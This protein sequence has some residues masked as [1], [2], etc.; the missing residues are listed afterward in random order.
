[1][2]SC[3]G[4]FFYPLH[5]QELADQGPGSVEQTHV[6]YEGQA[7]EEGLVGV[8]DHQEQSDNLLATGVVGGNELVS[9]RKVQ[10]VLGTSARKVQPN[11]TRITDFWR[12][13]DE[14]GPNSF[15]RGPSMRMVMVGGKYF[16]YGEAWKR[17]SDGGP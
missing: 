8:H 1:M 15:K 17:K 12:A 10:Q 13:S 11:Q 6:H 5:G 9:A 14:N 2:I 7:R 16:A 4:A 3:S